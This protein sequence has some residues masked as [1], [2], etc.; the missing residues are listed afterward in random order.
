VIFSFDI[1]R[2]KLVDRRENFDVPVAPSH[3]TFNATGSQRSSSN[4][5]GGE[6]RLMQ[7]TSLDAV[8]RRIGKKR[9][10]RKGKR[11]ISNLRE[12]AERRFPGSDINHS[13]SF[14]CRFA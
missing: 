10:K 3:C 5:A 11:K 7:T 2:L 13:L 12:P 9:K 4:S 8:V 1:S 14:L 6:D